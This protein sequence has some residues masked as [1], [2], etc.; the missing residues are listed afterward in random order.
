MSG[1]F[2]EAE[3]LR[4][5]ETLATFNPTRNRVWVDHTLH[6]GPRVAMEHTTASGVTGRYYVEF[7]ERDFAGIILRCLLGNP[8]IDVGP[9][10]IRPDVHERHQFKDHT[11]LRMVIEE[12]PD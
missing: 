3:E 10:L 4:P 9:P 5:L 8:E 1:P 6:D 7:N 2:G 11:S 12:G